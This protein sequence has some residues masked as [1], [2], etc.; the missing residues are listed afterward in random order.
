MALQRRNRCVHWFTGWRPL[1]SS[2]TFLTR[3]RQWKGLYY[4]T[5]RTVQKQYDYTIFFY[6]ILGYRPTRSEDVGANEVV[7]WS[8]VWL[9]RLNTGHGTV[10][11]FLTENKNPDLSFADAVRWHVRETAATGLEQL[12]EMCVWMC[13]TS[14]EK[15]SHP[16]QL[17][18]FWKWCKPVKGQS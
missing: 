9:W 17:G 7:Q 6:G 1:R 10:V 13:S 8:I 15:S 11:R 18:T 3:W 12:T 16:A 4:S 5:T 14:A 2:K